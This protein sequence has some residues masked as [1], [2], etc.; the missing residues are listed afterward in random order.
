M[1]GGKGPGDVGTA[2]LRRP[3]FSAELGLRRELSPVLLPERLNA[4]SLVGFCLV[5][6][7]C[8]CVWGVAAGAR[9]GS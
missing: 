4:Y 6:C 1:E 8:M 2:G 5:L 3:S 7:V 9:V